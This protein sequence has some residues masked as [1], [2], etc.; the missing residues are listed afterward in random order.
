MWVFG[1]LQS[2]TKDM[3]M[4]K[5]NISQT[6]NKTKGTLKWTLGAGILAA[7]ASTLCCILPLV[8]FMLG[9]SGAW[10]GN[11]TALAPYRPYFLTTAIILVLYGFWKVYKKPAAKDCKPGT[12]CALPASDRLNKVML[13]VTASIILLTLLYPYVAPMILKQL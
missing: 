6:K 5:S 12:Y 1:K 13:W 3:T 11:L 8:L 9:I 10:I 7:L 4:D 2:G